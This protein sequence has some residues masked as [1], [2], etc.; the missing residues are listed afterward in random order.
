MSARDIAFVVHGILKPILSAGVSD[1]DYYL[2]YIRRRGGPLANPIN[3]KRVLDLDKEMS[4]RESKAKEWA[5]EKSTLGYVAKSNVARPRALIATPKVTTDQ[6]ET[7]EKKQRANLWKARVYCDQAY[8]AYQRVVE[9]WRM[10]PPGPVPPQVQVHLA[11]LM[12]CMGISLDENKVY[13]CDAEPLK[14]LTKLG[15]GRTLIARVLEQALLPPNAVQAVMPNLLDTILALPADA[16]TDRVLRAIASVL[17]KL[18]TIT[19]A[20]LIRCLEVATQHGKSS[21]STPIRIECALALLSKGAQ[22]V[23]EDPSEEAK[24]A[25]GTAESQFTALL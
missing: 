7:E 4:S 17:V 24:A 12:K 8:Q 20:T 23:A 19:S 11:K 14:L 10:A 18:P 1:D 9:I 2:Q 3:P 25:W 13:T 21:V 15:K 22:V 5:S 6:E 16:T